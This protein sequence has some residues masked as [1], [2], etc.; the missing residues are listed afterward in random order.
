MENKKKRKAY[1]TN[2]EIIF[3]RPVHIRMPE[4]TYN[5][6]ARKA[7]KI[8]LFVGPFLRMIMQMGFERYEEL[9]NYRKETELK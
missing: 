3:D 6:Y 5:K 4:P 1:Y 2:T 9:E 7:K 8:N